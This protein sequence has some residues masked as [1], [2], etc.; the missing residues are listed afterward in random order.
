MA[1]RVPVTDTKA[2]IKYIEEDG[3]VILTDFT[4]RR[5]VEQVNSDAEPYINAILK[6]RASRSLP[7]ETTRCTRLFGRSTT[8]REAWLQQPALLE[9]VNHFL[10]TESFPYQFQGDPADAEKISTDAILSAAATMD[11]GPGVK[12][13]V[14][15]RDDF[16]WQTTHTSPCPDSYQ[17]G[18][19]VTMGLLVPGVKT[20]NQH[21][22]W[23]E[24]E[25]RKWS[26]AAQKQAGYVLDNPFL[27]HCNEVNPVDM[28]RA[29]TDGLDELAG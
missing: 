20:E 21:L 29:S 13:Q 17:L 5:D 15:H 11:I 6:D 4:S 18:R 25:V 23:K 3:G 9:M 24:D 2:A 28:F 22:W 14:P 27:G 16:I 8:A 26:Q 1:R 12:A 7:R 19:D 10:R